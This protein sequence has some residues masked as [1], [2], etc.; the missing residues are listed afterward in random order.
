MT[1]TVYTE[2]ENEEEFTTNDVIKSMVD[3]ILQGDAVNAQNSFASLMSGKVA[4]AIDKRRLEI[5]QSLY[6]REQE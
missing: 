1:T 5:S 4:D 2:V 3:T 6:T